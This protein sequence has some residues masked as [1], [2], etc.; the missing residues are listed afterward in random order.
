MCR[1]LGSEITSFWQE[2]T[3]QEEWIDSQ[4]WDGTSRFNSHS[5]HHDTTS[6]ERD[7]AQEMVNE[8]YVAAVYEPNN[9][10]RRSFFKEHRV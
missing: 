6:S 2:N 3:I 8:G 7:V 1:T 9:E 10:T 4:A 5:V